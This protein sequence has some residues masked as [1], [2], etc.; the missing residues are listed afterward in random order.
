VESEI[1]DQQPMLITAAGLSPDGTHF[2]Y[3]YILTQN[4]YVKRI[5]ILDLAAGTQQTFDITTDAQNITLG[6]WTDD[7]IYYYGSGLLGELWTSSTYSVFDPVTGSI[8]ETNQAVVR[9]GER[10]DLT[11]EIIESVSDSNYL[12][13]SSMDVHEAGELNVL[14]YR[15]TGALSDQPVQIYHDPLHLGNVGHWVLD[16]NA[17]LY[18]DD[19]LS[20]TTVIRR[21]G[22]STQVAIGSGATFVS[23]TPDGWVMQTNDLVF[24]YYREA[25]DH[26]GAIPIG[27][28]VNAQIFNPVTLVWRTPL[29]ATANSGSFAA[30]D[31]DAYLMSNCDTVDY[32]FDWGDNVP[33]PVTVYEAPD[34][35]SEILA[36]IDTEVT[37]LN[38]PICPSRVS[39][40]WIVQT[41]DDRRGWI[42]ETSPRSTERC[43][44]DPRRSCS[45]VGTTD[46]TYGADID[47]YDAP[48]GT[49][50]DLIPP[51]DPFD[52]IAGPVCTGEHDTWMQIQT[53]AGISGWVLEGICGM[54]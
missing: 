34:N 2:A 28:E 10:L 46:Y 12:R 27:G 44:R 7:G 54:G 49:V 33:G 25:D 39:A 14:E 20:T 47:V 32:W 48:G 1:P 40:W 29:G 22:S 3:S 45:P 26:I 5:A 53:D 17:V 31:L 51:G 21:D 11:G 15:P 35:E 19:A 41:D 52:I 18:Y 38:G 50:I 24:M 16:G 36:E 6:P 9:A 42:N 43:P 23:G 30:A 4:P 8:T 37:I 13:P